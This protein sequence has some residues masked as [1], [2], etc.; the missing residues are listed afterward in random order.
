MSSLPLPPTDL[1]SMPSVLQHRFLVMQ[2]PLCIL[3]AGYCLWGAYKNKS[4]VPIWIFVGGGIA[5][6]ME[7]FM[8]VMGLVWYPPDGMSYIFESVGRR[9]PW[10]GF[11]AYLWFLGG[12]SYFVYERLKK[13]MT[14]RQLWILYAI[15]VVVEILLEVPGLN[16]GDSQARVYAYYGNQP[17]LFMRFPLWFPFLNGGAP[18]LAGALVFRM[19]PFIKPILRPIILYAVPLANSVIMVG[20]GLPVEFTLN[21]NADLW[22]TRLAGALTIGLACFMIYIV[23]LATATDSKAATLKAA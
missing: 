7:P 20:A 16:M 11:F 5:Y 19:L 18:I 21:A 6:I 17:F 1:M 9:V 2:F 3:S 10:F 8:G 23:A 12:M 15:L 4:L 14:T 13:G 22:A